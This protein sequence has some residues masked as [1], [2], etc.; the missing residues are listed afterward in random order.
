MHIVRLFFCARVRPW[1]VMFTLFTLGTVLF[2]DFLADRGYSIPANS[3]PTPIFQGNRD[4][5]NVSFA[6]NVFWGE[7]IMPDMLQVLSNAQVKAT[8]FI[9]GS[10]AKRHPDSLKLIADAGHELGNHSFT[11]PHPNRLSKSQNQDEILR[12]EKLIEEITGMKTCLYA[13]P[14]GEYNRTVLE[15]AQELG[16]TTIMW[17]ADT[18]DWRRPS[19]EVIIKRIEGKLQNGAIILMHPT[20]PTIK[21]LPELIR[22]IKSKGYTILPISDIIKK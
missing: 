5:A 8:F 3:G 16:Y 9:G 17:T 18:I 21:A 20:E 1:Y 19:P 11:H 6:C 13:P 22:I 10:W 4:H 15:A 12:T 7:D 14:Y 2:T